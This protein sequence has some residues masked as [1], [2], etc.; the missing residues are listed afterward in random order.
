MLVEE[1]EQP[2]E[3]RGGRLVGGEQV[4]DDDAGGSLTG[5]GALV[6]GGVEQVRDHV[7]GV[8]P[9]RRAPVFDEAGHL[10]RQVAVDPVQAPRAQDAPAGGQGQY[11]GQERVL[12]P[13]QEGGNPA[14]VGPQAELGDQVGGEVLQCGDGV[15]R[16]A[17]PPGL[18]VPGGGGR[19]AVLG[20]GAHAGAVQAASRQA[21]GPH[22]QGQVLGGPASVGLL[23]QQVPADGV[24]GV[25]V[26]EDLLGQ[27]R[28]VREVQVVVDA[29][30]VAVL[31]LV[32]QEAELVAFEGASV[33]VP[34]GPGGAG[35]HAEQRHAHCP[36]T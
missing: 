3:R 7:R 18:C 26:L 33:A 2:G 1:E 17:R 29:D 21:A 22:P 15:D 32:E 28:R 35:R 11:G 5:D 13:G 34:P 14:G 24:R 10:G 9:V 23:A 30:E 36:C 19:E 27:G 8:V 31:P 25:G 16:A 20:G 4:G 6:T 12:Q